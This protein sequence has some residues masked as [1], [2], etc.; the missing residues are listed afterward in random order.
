MRIKSQVVKKETK[1]KTKPMDVSSM[2][3]SVVF[4]G[5]CVWSIIMNPKPPTVKRKLL[6][7]PSMI[8]WP[9]TR[10]GM[11]ATGLECPCSSTVAPTLGGSTMTS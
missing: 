1:I 8:Y 6:A 7:K 5:E 3:L 9:F 11:N 4:P 2:R 10:Y